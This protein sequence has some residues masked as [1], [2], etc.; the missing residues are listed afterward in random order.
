M[1]KNGVFTLT[2]TKWLSPN[3][4]VT[5]Q[6]KSGS[7][8]RKLMMY[9]WW[10]ISVVYF[11]FIS[12]KYNHHC[13]GLSP[14][15]HYPKAAIQER[16]REEIVEWFCNVIT[17]TLTLLTSQKFGWEIIPRLVYSPDLTLSDF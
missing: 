14:S 15:L 8:P 5:P 2:L 11:E 9:I 7:H 6:A 1:T 3:G 13:W 17:P 4:R 10:N 16:G 12:E